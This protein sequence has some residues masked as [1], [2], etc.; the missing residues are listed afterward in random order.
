MA[1]EEQKKRARTI[2]NE[3]FGESLWTQEEMNRVQSG[4]LDLIEQGF[5]DEQIVQTLTQQNPNVVAA[6]EARVANAAADAMNRITLPFG[7][8]TPVSTTA[9]E[10]A[11]TEGGGLTPEQ[12]ALFEA[13]LFEAYGAVPLPDGNY[14]IDGRVYTYDQIVGGALADLPS[15]GGGGGGAAAPVARFSI[16]QVGDELFRFNDLDGSLTPLGI[17]VP[18]GVQSTQVDRNGNLIGVRDDGTSVVIQRGFDFPATDP[19]RVFALQEAGVTGMYNGAPTESRRQFD[20]SFAENQRQFNT[21]EERQRSRLNLEGELGRRAATLNEAEF[22][23]QVAAEPVDFLF[24]AALTRGQT[25]PL[26]RITPEA[27]IG[28][29]NADLAAARNQQIPSAAVS[30][31]RLEPPPLAGAAP[32]GVP[33]VAPQPRLVDLNTAL[34]SGQIDAGAALE[35]A[36]LIPKAEHGGVYGGRM[37]ITGDSSD[38]KENEELVIDLPNDE[39][40]MVIPKDRIIGKRKR[41]RMESQDSDS[42]AGIPRMQNGGILTNSGYTG[43]AGSGYGSLPGGGGYYRNPDGATGAYGNVTPEG[44]YTYLRTFGGLDDATAQSASGYTPV[45]ADGGGGYGGEGGT[46][47]YA[48]LSRMTAPPGVRDV[49]EGRNPGAL[50]LPLPLPTL[51]ALNNL[52]GSEAQALNTALGAEFGI[53][54]EEVAKAAQQRFLAPNSRRARLVV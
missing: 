5:T 38:G 12:L 45:V 29:F 48:A 1:S 46:L 54:L 39:G 51:Q 18:P 50:R 13:N 28:Q 27:I 33:A 49:I 19:A 15:L 32:T 10:A 34:R 11:T 4:I 3:F 35:Q 23:R 16:Q 26:P 17:S 47:D 14:L 30:Q 53:G 36:R 8:G 24:R 7:G 20:T 41:K 37:V 52:T 21:S 22:A 43:G 42:E 44:Q 6:N 31:P 9:P 2:W 25:S 40:L